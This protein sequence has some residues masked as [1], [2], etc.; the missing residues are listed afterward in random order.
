MPGA[1]PSLSLQV[2]VPDSALLHCIVGVLGV[3]GGAVRNVGLNVA[4]LH[5]LKFVSNCVSCRGVN[6]IA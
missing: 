1:V 4:A 3:E 2:V 5:G 6:D